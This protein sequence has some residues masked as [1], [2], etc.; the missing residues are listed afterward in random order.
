M[1]R[2]LVPA[3][4]AVIALAAARCAAGHQPWVIQRYTSLIDLDRNG[5]F[6]A[7][8]SVDADFGA[9]T[10]PGISRDIVSE[11][12]FGNGQVREYPITLIEV[13]DAEGRRQNVETASEGA[14]RRFRIGDPNHTVSGK[15]SYRI[16]YQVHRALTAFPDRDELTWNATGTWP[17]RMMT[18]AIVV[19][20][21]DGG[22]VNAT[23]FEGKPGATD[24]CRSSYTEKAATFTATRPL[25]E[26]EQVTVVVSF[27]KGVFPTPEPVLVN[28]RTGMARLF[29]A[30]PS[31]VGA[32]V[33]LC[34]AIAGGVAAVWWRFGRGTR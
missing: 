25:A 21:P 29:D 7:R 30:M 1:T 13:T 5:A 8:E 9:Q 31:L 33:V 26:G 27:R 17:V 19:R 15:Q 23:C 10:L 4:C 20:P 6:I 18:A 32:A 22:I 14:L 12:T 11:Q 3:A 2:R 28:R 24:R 34:L 16:A